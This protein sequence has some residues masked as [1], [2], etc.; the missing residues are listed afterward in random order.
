MKSEVRQKSLFSKIGRWAWGARAIWRLRRKHKPD[1]L[2]FAVL[3]LSFFAALPLPFLLEGFI[4]YQAS[5]LVCYAIALVGLNLLSG[6]NGQLSLGHGAFFGIGAF[7]TAILARTFSI[8]YFICIPLSGM[9][10][11]VFGF[12]LG[13]PA[14]RLE[15]ASLA[16]ATFAM[17]LSL[18]QLLEYFETY[19][20]GTTGIQVDKAP[21][22]RGMTFTEEQ[23]IFFLG[24]IFLLVVQ[25]LIVNT[26]DSR[27]GRAVRAIRDHDIAS[28]ALGV[29]NRLYKVTT[30][31]VSAAIT[32]VGGAFFALT[33]GHVAPATFHEAMSITFLTGLVVGGMGSIMG[34]IFGATFI[35][36]LPTYTEQISRSLTAFVYG[37]VLILFI[38]L[39]PGGFVGVL[40]WLRIQMKNLW[41]FVRF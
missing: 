8:P 14:L 24:L 38:Y 33:S 6:Y 18:P 22:P 5:T 1:T 16:L 11:F 37:L 27:L 29:D 13:I 26:V 34:P 10:T 25:I 4:L 40:K 32:G 2:A 41:S 19:T 39:N 23:W 31:G 20:G 36:F 9:V 28:E 21:V 12:L 7:T 3:L 30:F 17:A 15:R 35:Q